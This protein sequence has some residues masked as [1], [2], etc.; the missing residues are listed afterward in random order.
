MPKLLQFLL[1]NA[2][3]GFGVAGVFV[4]ALI[5]LDVGGFA[6]LTARSDV[7]P[8]AVSVLTFFLGLTFA[9]AQMGIAVMMLPK[10]DGAGP[11]GGRRLPAELTPAYARVRV[12][13]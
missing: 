7:A 2:V 5:A 13:R 8:M 3:I 10:D 1:V 4:A 11:R 6:T 12:R 9:S